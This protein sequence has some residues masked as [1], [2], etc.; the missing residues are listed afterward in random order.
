M[1]KTNCEVCGKEFKKRGSAKTCS[2]EHSYELK[3]VRKVA[4]AKANPDKVRQY[5]GY[6]QSKPEVKAKRNIRQ[7]QIRNA[8][9]LL[10]IRELLEQALSN[11]ERQPGSQP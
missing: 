6:Y 7:N 10:K 8:I 3:K 5:T 9:T 1:T 2:K 11:G 4:W